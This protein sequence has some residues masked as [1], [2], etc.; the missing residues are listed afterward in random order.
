MVK[1]KVNAEN[2]THTKFSVVCE[3]LISAVLYV[4]AHVWMACVC[5]EM[6]YDVFLIMGGSHK[7]L[8][9]TGLAKARKRSNIKHSKSDLQE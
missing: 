7:S 9:T 4:C 3:I 5:W 1:I 2:I 6:I 8:K